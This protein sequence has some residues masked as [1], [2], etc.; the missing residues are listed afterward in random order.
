MRLEGKVAVVTGG[1]RGI[2][3]AIAC[4]YA[5]EGAIVVVAARTQVEIEETAEMI[6]RKGGKT[7]ALK[8]DVKDARQVRNLM[9]KAVAEYGKIDILVNNAGVGNDVRDPI[10]KLKPKDWDKVFRVNARGPYLC[11]K[12]ALPYMMAQ[13]RGSIINISSLLAM[14]VEA[15][16]GPYCASKAALDTL[17]KVLALEVKQYNISVNALF[18]GALVNTQMARHAPAWKR[19]TMLPP[20]H[21]LPAAIF[22]SAQDGAGVTGQSIN[23]LEWSQTH[24]F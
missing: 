14:E 4:G 6:N 18:P 9:R 2:G 11:S 22:L 8:A 3:R 20:E 12:E 1:G 24:G 16:L 21:M 7:L 10:A 5:S 17:T 23:A 13:M 15:N 19:A